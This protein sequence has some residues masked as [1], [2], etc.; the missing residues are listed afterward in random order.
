VT[1][2]NPVPSL[3]NSIFSWFLGVNMEH[4]CDRLW[5]MYIIMHM[6]YIMCPMCTHITNMCGMCIMYKPI[7][8]T[9]H[10]EIHNG[11]ALPYIIYIT[12]IVRY[13]YIRYS[14]YRYTIY[15]PWKFK[16]WLFGEAEN[17]RP[18]DHK[19][20]FSERSCLVKTPSIA[21][22]GQQ[23]KFFMKTQFFPGSLTSA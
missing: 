20:H 17:R 7:Y 6:L 2:G 21:I 8:K 18:C 22:W 15:I 9:Y 19:V 13:M 3:I 1:E 4:F 14:M 11:G 5:I 10:K 23:I 16:I 12:Y